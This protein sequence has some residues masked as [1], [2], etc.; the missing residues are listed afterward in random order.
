M[1]A[2]GCEVAVEA[3][4]SGKVL[5]DVGHGSLCWLNRVAKVSAPL[6]ASGLG[7]RARLSLACSHEASRCSVEETRIVSEAAEADVAGVAERP[8]YDVLPM[9]VVD[10][11]LPHPRLLPAWVSLLRAHCSYFWSDCATWL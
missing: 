3:V 8:P 5:R 2:Q 10:V 4:Q 1:R 6:L 7:G 9:T 11:Q